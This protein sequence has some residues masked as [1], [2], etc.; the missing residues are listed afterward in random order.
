[1]TVLWEFFNKPLKEIIAM[2]PS[3]LA[4]GIS[5]GTTVAFVLTPLRPV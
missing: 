2:N 5:H 4:G 1:M 3:I